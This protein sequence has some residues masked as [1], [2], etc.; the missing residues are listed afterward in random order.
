[1]KRNSIW[2]QIELELR[3]DKKL[4]PN[5]PIHI[6]AQAAIVGEKA[7]VLINECL[8]QKYNVK[9]SENTESIK[10]AAIQ[11]AVKAIRFLEQFD[12]ISQ[13]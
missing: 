3:N 8:Q 4:Q 6:V 13:Q 5:W 1:M 9:Q 2:E 7:G 12:T 11:T 10:K